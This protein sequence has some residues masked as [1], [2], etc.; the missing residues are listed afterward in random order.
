M[1]GTESLAIAGIWVSPKTAKA[2]GTTLPPAG[3]PRWGE[4]IVTPDRTR[5]AKPY[6]WHDEK[7]LAES[8]PNANGFGSIFRKLSAGLHPWNGGRTQ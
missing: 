2:E 8:Q 1:T 3:S 5:H 6:V 7:T 4:L